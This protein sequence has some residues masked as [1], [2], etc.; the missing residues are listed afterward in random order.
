MGD[1]CGVKIVLISQHKLHVS[2][3]V[4]AF[5]LLMLQ[6]NGPVKV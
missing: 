1:P 5:Q 3:S 2:D 6:D 4:S